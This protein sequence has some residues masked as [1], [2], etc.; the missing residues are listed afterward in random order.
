MFL[1]VTTIAHRS[2][3][4]AIVGDL[5]KDFRYQELFDIKRNTDEL[6]DLLK[7]GPLP[8]GYD[9]VMRTHRVRLTRIA[10]QFGYELSDD[11]SMQADME[12]VKLIKQRLDLM[13][14]EAE[15]QRKPETTP[16]VTMN[17]G[18][19]LSLSVEK[20]EAT[21]RTVVKN[22]ALLVWEKS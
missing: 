1:A 10:R 5:P 6:L 15:R 17:I 18:D 21:L 8:S 2:N 12:C 20:F 13:L 16:T 3:S 19:L 7:E 22:E 14:K 9:N 11:P 4:T